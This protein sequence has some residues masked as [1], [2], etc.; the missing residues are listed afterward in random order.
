VSQ[1][2]AAGLKQG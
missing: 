2:I 1:K